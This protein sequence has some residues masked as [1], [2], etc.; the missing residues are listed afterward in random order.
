MSWIGKTLLEIQY[1]LEA[2]T[3][4]YG[5]VLCSNDWATDTQRFQKTMLKAVDFTLSHT[6]I[7]TLLRRPPLVIGIDQ[8]R[9]VEQGTSEDIPWQ[10][11]MPCELC[12]QRWYKP[13][14]QLGSRANIL[15]FHVS[16]VCTTFL[17]SNNKRWPTY[18]KSI[19]FQ[20]QLL[21]A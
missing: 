6:S 12:Q 18:R 11:P 21:G 8:T 15:I 19:K 14:V 2:L 10:V 13:W 9:W 1:I 3:R 5:G 7:T 17:N 16:S 4:L 20:T